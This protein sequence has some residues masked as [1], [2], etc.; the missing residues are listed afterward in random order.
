MTASLPPLHDDL[1]FNAPMSARRADHLAAFAGRDPGHVLDVGCG[2]AELLLRT[3]ELSPASRGTGVDVDRDALEHARGLAAARG[4]SERVTLVEG[5]GAQV[6]HG[7][8]DAV[9]SVGARHVWGPD[10]ATALGRLRGMVRRGGR[11]VYGDGIWSR[12]PTASAVEHLG[13]SPD[14]Y[15]TLAD[16]VDAALA[17]GFRVLAVGEATQQE[18]DAFESGYSAGYERWLLAHP[19]DPDADDVRAR[20]AEHRGAYLRGYR[21]I[22]G[23]SF[24]E[25]VAA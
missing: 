7:P 24:L 4:L 10:D 6:A 11:V 18:W 5:D 19:D 1:L 14:E 15:G 12:P 25:L 3:V 2:W 21:G 9:L 16:V 23:H 20:A 8:V 17:A 13:G 22:L